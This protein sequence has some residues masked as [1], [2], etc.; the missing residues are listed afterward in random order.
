MAQVYYDNETD[1]Y[2]YY[3]ANDIESGEEMGELDENNTSDNNIKPIENATIKPGKQYDTDGSQYDT[4]QHNGNKQPN[5]RP[6]TQDEQQA[7]RPAKPDNQR[8]R[9]SKKYE[10]DESESDESDSESET[11]SESDSSDSESESSSES[12]SE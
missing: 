9:R 10:S 5:D 8:K 4:S 2:F 1:E 3:N 11:D 6:A 7:I 12:S